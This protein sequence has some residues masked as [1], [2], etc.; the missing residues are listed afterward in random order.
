MKKV[1]IGSAQFLSTLSVKMKVLAGFA[2][3]I[4]ITGIVGGFAYRGFT[5][6]A[7]DVD[8]YAGAVEEAALIARIEAHFLDLRAHAREFSLLGHDEDAAAV[9]AQA[10]AIEPELADAMAHVADEAHRHE[11]EK[12]QHAFEVYMKDFAKAEVLEREFKS[13]VR[14]DLDPAAEKIVEDLDV[15]VEEAAARGNADAV[16]YATTAREHAL[17]AWTYSNIVLDRHDE[18][19]APKAEHEIEEFAIALEALGKAV[20]TAHERELHQELNGLFERYRS[21]FHKAHEDRLE[22]HTLFHGEMAEAAAEIVRDAESLQEQLATFEEEIREETMDEIT[23]AEIEI[24][25]AGLIALGVGAAFA[26]LLGNGISRPVQTMT[27]AMGGLANGDL[28][29]DIPARDRGDEIGKMAAAVQVFKDNAIRTKELEAEQEQTKQRAEEERR[30]MMRR[31]ADDLEST[32][33]NIVDGVTSTAN[34]MESSANDMSATAEETSRQ[35]AAVSAAAEEGST[36]VQ[37]VASAAE[38]LAGSIR[39][40]SRQVQ[41]QSEIALQASEAAKVSDTQVQALSDAAQKIGE[42]VELITSIADQTNLLALNATIEAARAG[43]AGKGF[44]VVA[45]E[46]KNLANQTSKATEEI[47]QQIQ[48]MQEQTG[49]TVNAIRDITEQ[50]ERITEVSSAVASAVEEQN[51]AT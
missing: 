34:G 29:A 43:E 4:L 6:V 26:Y 35:A 47:A 5:I 15:I 42:V 39:E 2:V 23:A 1:S 12:L 45:S 3:M 11:L 18:S 7:D 49:S 32:M 50:I 40:I 31:L 13:L 27:A 46:V 30:D 41:L 9:H 17:L 16:T 8:I 20:R 21:A 28:D 25:V 10:K 48:A 22:L 44:A 38:E 51:A 19:F 37:A 33:G 14:N 36:N 24:L